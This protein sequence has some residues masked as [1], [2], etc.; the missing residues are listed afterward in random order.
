M[1]IADRWCLI[2]HR[3][4]AG[5]R[6]ASGDRRVR[7]SLAGSRALPAHLTE[8]NS[9]VL[10]RDRERRERE[11][12]PHPSPCINDDT[13]KY[14]SEI[15]GVMVEWLRKNSVTAGG[16]TTRTV[17]VLHGAIRDDLLISERHTSIKAVE[18]IGQSL[19][20]VL[21]G[22]S[23]FSDRTLRRRCHDWV[24]WSIGRL[25]R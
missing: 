17:E 16:V 24:P 19:S 12:R 5:A 1:Y 7:R 14:E 22:K 15:Y 6:T 25:Q 11:S 13:E 20:R 8:Q 21:C 9:T 18:P 23:P 4:W 10:H 3:H 2:R